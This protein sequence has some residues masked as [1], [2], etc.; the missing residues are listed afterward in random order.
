MSPDLVT[1]PPTECNVK[2]GLGQECLRSPRV[3][4]DRLGCPEGT[5]RW[6]AQGV[7]VVGDSKSVGRHLG[8]RVRHE[9]S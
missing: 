6:K 3:R 5:G 8:L 1:L 7:D 9:V 4:R 2:C